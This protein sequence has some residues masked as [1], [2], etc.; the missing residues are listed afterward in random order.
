[1]RIERIERS[2]HRQERV[3]VYLEGGDLLRVTGAELLRFGLYKG[4]DL[5]P[6]LVVELQAAAQKSQLKQTA[7]RM[8]SG[9]ML[10]KKEV[11]RRLT[12]KGA[13]EA[14]AAEMADWLESLGAVDD[15]GYAGAVAR[16]YGAMGYGAGR[17]RQ[18]LMRRGV[19]RELWDEALAQ[20]PPAGE[21]IRR[22]LDAKLR[23]RAMTP[24]ESRRLAAALQRRGFSWNDI[25]PA[26]NERGQEIDDT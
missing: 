7:A 25:R 22:F 26:L 8:A 12:K 21:A 9:R 19:P 13:D 3:L 11:Q 4:M 10:S 1:M 6:Q 20:L 14:Q 17:V 24:E 15:A 2:K 18:E 16:H 5:T 23:G